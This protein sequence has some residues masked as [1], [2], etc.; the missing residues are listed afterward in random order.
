MQELWKKYRSLNVPGRLIA[1]TVVVF[2]LTQLYNLFLTLCCITG[3]HWQQYLALDA[4]VYSFLLKP[5]TLLTYMFVHADLTQDVFHLLFNMICLYWFGNF[6]LRY[7]TGRQL[8]G[9]YL[10]GGL[11]AGLV[12]LFVYN[13][14]P[15]FALDR[16]S[17]AVV[18]ASGAIFALIVAVAIHR[19][20]E[21]VTLLLLLWRCTVRM[22]WIAI[23]AVALSVLSVTSANAGGN[24]CHVGGALWGAVYGLMLRRGV[25]ITSGFNRLA[26]GLVG[27]FRPRRKMKVMRGGAHATWTGDCAQDR[28]YNRRRRAEEAQIDAILDKMRRSGYNGLTEEEKRTLFSAGKK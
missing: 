14:F 2:V 7:H 4:N 15:Y 16:N 10:T 8:L 24:V 26:D 11:F 22:K 17:T 20:D 9:L 25:D 18:G 19:P 28:D 27:L 5:W 12:F 21:R 23:V 6:Y 1:I 13:V 3:Y